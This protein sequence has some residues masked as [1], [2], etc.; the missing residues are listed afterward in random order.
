M[1]RMLKTLGAALMAVCAMGAVVVSGASATNDVFRSERATTVLTGEQVEKIK[2]TL[3]G[4]A[5]EC[6]VAT[7]EATMAGASPSSVTTVLPHYGSCTYA[8]EEAVVNMHACRYNLTGITDASGDA[9]MS[10]VDCG[11]VIELTLKATKCIVTV[12]NQTAEEGVH[13]TNDGAGGTRGIL[14][15][16]TAKFKVTSVMDPVEG[17]TCNILTNSTGTLDGTITFTGEEDPAG[18]H[19]G[20]WVE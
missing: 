8:G 5:I 17:V 13:Y 3:A 2:F 16:L 11:T 12:G 15:D 1:A 10:I 18:A 20:I 9:Q 14:I 4:Q 7:F 6:S 19:V